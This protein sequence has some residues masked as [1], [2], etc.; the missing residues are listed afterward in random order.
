MAPSSSTSD[1]KQFFDFIWFLLSI[2]ADMHPSRTLGVCL[3][4]YSLDNFVGSEPN[5]DMAAFDGRATTSAEHDA[6]I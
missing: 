3:P 4:C 2:A 1:R 5:G 6:K